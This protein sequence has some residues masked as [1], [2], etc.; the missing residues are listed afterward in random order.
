MSRASYDD[1]YDYVVARKENLRHLV[2]FSEAYEKAPAQL[3]LLTK[4]PSQS[5]SQSPTGKRKSENKDKILARLR[6]VLE[7]ARE[8]EKE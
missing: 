4:I 6:S 7:K 3:S 5:P 8:I 1:I 2:E